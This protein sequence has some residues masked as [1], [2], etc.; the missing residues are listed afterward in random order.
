MTSSGRV[1]EATRSLVDDQ[2]EI[3]QPLREVVELDSD[4]DG[5]TFD[6][7]PLDSGQFGELVSRDIATETDGDAYQLADPDAVRRAIGDTPQ[8]ETT[9]EETDRDFALPVG[10]P[11]VDPR[12]LATVVVGL[13]AMVVTRSMYYTAVFRE[14]YRVSPANDPYF[15]R[16][17][18]AELL[19]RSNG[20]TDLSMLAQVGDL[21]GTRPLTHALNWWFAELLGGTPGAA[22]TVAVWAPIFLT[23]ALGIVLYGLVVLLTDDHRIALASLLLL[24]LTPVHVVYTSLGFLEHRP[25]QYLWLTL[26]VFTL[27]WLAIDVRRRQQNTDGRTAATAHLRSPQSWAVAGGLAFAVAASAHAWGGSP[28]TFVPVALYLG[29]RP[30]ADVRANVPPLPALA[31]TVAGVGAGTLVAALLYLQFGWHESTAVT[32]SLLVT[33]GGVSVA[34]VATVWRR[35]DLP[36]AGLTVT[37]GVLG[38]TGIVLLR[39]LRP[40]DVSR[41]RG[42]ADDLFGRESATETSSLFATDTGVL[43]EPLFQLGLGFFLALVPLGVATWYVYR[44]YRPA[45]LVVVPFTWY[46]L[47]LA[48]IQIRF[49][50]QFA[51]FVVVF[52]G[53]ALVYLLGSIDLAREPPVFS[54]PS[55]R[56]RITIA[57]P[58]DPTRGAYLVGTVGL[59]LLFNLIFVP[60]LLAQAQYGDDKIEAMATIDAHADDH[61]HTEFVL[62]RWGENRMYNYFVSGES[63]GYGYAR[64]N[65]ES[66]IF[67][68]DPDSW[69]DRFESRVGYVVLDNFDGDTPETSVYTKLFD[70][71]GA[72]EDTV[73]HYQ[74][75]Y[76]GEDARAFVVVPGAAIATTADPG[77]NVTASTDVTIAGESFTYERTTTANETGQVAIRVAYP[78]EYEVG[79]ETVQVRESDVLNG[80]EVSVGGA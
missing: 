9:T 65:Y 63:Q 1:E 30:T 77:E 29:L 46:Y 20:V 35:F 25:Y 79:S 21:T 48:A 78:G 76:S 45:W 32:A 43:L 13:L 3:E 24:A 36:V 15:Y 39:W 8:P 75:L 52:G 6:D 41:F 11:A 18:Q 14:G 47:V 64:G 16:W 60:T 27:V 53:I 26:L 10:L 66:F 34:L 57:L 5:W 70:E 37:E 73:T 12:V 4:S 71:F 28:L 59:L 7:I 44:E 38:V 17:W 49:G 80:T 31:P 55:A 40:E 42:R 72:G 69:Y 50:A 68:E 54:G 2:P 58:D 33:V 67:A 56:E 23:V 62:S 74:L 19:E 51:I 22:D 61:E